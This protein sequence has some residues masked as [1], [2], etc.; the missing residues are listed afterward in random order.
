[1]KIKFVIRNKRKV[2]DFSLERIIDFPYIPPIGMVFCFP[3]IPGIDEAIV[4]GHYCEPEKLDEF[5]AEVWLDTEEDDGLENL[6]LQTEKGWVK[7]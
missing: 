1:M 6:Q 7:T 2:K 5:V 4:D 3:G